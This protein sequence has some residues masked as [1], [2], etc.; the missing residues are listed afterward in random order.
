MPAATLRALAKLH[1]IAD[2]KKL[3]VST[4]AQLMDKAK[5]MILELRSAKSFDQ[6]YA[7]NQVK[8]HEATIEI[9]QDEIKNGDDADLKALT[10]ELKK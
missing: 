7:N 10:A 4:D 3:K 2:K 5:T 1:A 6:A 9:F 8:A